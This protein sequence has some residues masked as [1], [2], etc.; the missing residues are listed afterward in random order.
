MVNTDSP[1]NPTQR[2][3]EI[4]LSQI[5]SLLQP[6]GIIASA[7]RE[8]D[9]LYVLLE[10][11]YVP[12]RQTM[13]ALV[14]LG[15]A[16]LDDATIAKIW[17]YGRPFGER[18]TTWSHKIELSSYPHGFQPYRSDSSV[19]NFLT[20]K[21]I[22]S[23][24]SDETPKSPNSQ[25]Q[26]KADRFLVCGLGNLGQHCV[27]SLKSFS[28]TENETKIIA[29]NFQQP[30]TWVI[31]GLSELLSEPLILGDCRQDKVLEQA[32]I[33]D[34]RAVAI[35]TSDEST[36]IETAIVIRRLNPKARLVVRSGKQNLNELLQQK[37][38]NFIA[39]EPTELPA[40]SFALAALGEETLGF[41]TVGERQMRVMKQR[42]LVGD[43]RFENFPIYQLHK[44]N[45][46]LLNYPH[47]AESLELKTPLSEP[48]LDNLAKPPHDNVE[49]ETPSQAF[50]HWI[51]S[52]RVR[53]GDTVIYIE[54][55]E[56]TLTELAPLPGLENLTN[57]K[58]LQKYWRANWREKI[59]QVKDWV[60]Q[61]Q[62][63]RIVATGLGT[64]LILGIVGTIILKFSVPYLSW[65]TAISQAIILLLGGYGDV[66]GG[67]DTRQV[68]PW[69]V[70]FI[71]LCITAFSLLFVLG[72]LGLLADRLLSTRLDFLKPRPASPQSNHIVLVGLGRVGRR[73]A[74]LLIDLRQPFICLTDQ[75]EQKDLTPNVP[76]V[77]NQ[78]SRGLKEV[79]LSHA[80]SVIVV[81]DDQMLNLEVA[82]MAR[83]AALKVNRNINLIV[84]NYDQHFRDN[85][86]SLLPDAKALCAYALSAEAFVG[87]MFGENIL[88]LFRMEKQTI[89]VTEY[90]IEAGDTL[91]GKILAQV[92][93]GYGV[94]PIYYQSTQDELDKIIPSD[95][96]RLRVGDRLVVLASINGLKRIEWGYITPPRKWELQVLKPLNLGLTHYAGDTLENISGC[97]LS[98]AREFMNNLPGV[99]KVP[100]VMELMLYDHQAYRLIQKLGKILPTR[101]VAVD[102]D[103]SP[104]LDLSQAP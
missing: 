4:T 73:I 61:D 68:V 17:I 102:Q 62:T 40:A 24:T 23:H 28:S 14:S 84:R 36:N 43:Y 65:Q 29:I 63:R 98:L 78:I 56:Q 32:G 70:Q 100:G 90:T 77:Y 8:Q 54:E 69:W 47:T 55:I 45:Y 33:R 93:Y 13:V 41:F 9:C 95:E 10:S 91:N 96:T 80:K 39:F 7:E 82:L 18:F 38:D 88:S 27:A 5:N 83:D 12:D 42:V 11:D 50:Y 20:A 34:C 22:N 35:V 31:E 74:S 44:K 85:V 58:S 92:A 101:L 46:R 86:A 64:A 48:N 67:L 81:T 57:W 59:S 52:Q 94:V 1:T 37:L 79:N 6:H 104:N 72:A 3:I 71:C 16:N 75:L 103:N 89:L 76:V 66:F 49:S 15:I 19:N 97:S 26:I 25:F 21:K 87:A 53:A 99:L 2:N 51:P 60:S 30:D